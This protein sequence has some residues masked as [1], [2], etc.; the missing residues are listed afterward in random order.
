MIQRKT[1]QGDLV[2]EAVRKLGSH[3]TADEVYEAVSREHPH[4]SRGTV[5]R[6]LQRL[7]QAGFIRKVEVPDGA[8]RYDALCHDHYHVRCERC[9]RLFDVDMDVIPDL[10]RSIRDAHGFLFTGH[11]ILFQGICPECQSAPENQNGGH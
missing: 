11:N 2:L 6:N 7:S 3:V 1:I 9:G 4:I 8:D 5:Y 10:E